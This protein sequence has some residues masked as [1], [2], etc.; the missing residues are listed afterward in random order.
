MAASHVL[1]QRAWRKMPVRLRRSSGVQRLRSIVQPTTPT[2]V[3]PSPPQR[4]VRT[5]EELDEMLGEMDKAGAISDDAIRAGFGTFRMELDTPM[6]P[7]P[8]SA[9]FRSAVLKEYELVRGEPYTLAN[10]SSHL[11]VDAAVDDPFPYSTRS[12]STVGGQLI[13]I[14]HIIKTMNLPAGS[15]ILEF[16]AGWGNTT[17]ALAQ[18]GYD[19]TVVDMEPNFLEVIRR[20]TERVGRT[21]TLLKGDFGLAE[22][23]GDDEYDAVLFFAS[24]HHCSDHVSLLRQLERVLAPGGIMMFVGENIDDTFRRPWGLRMDGE[25]LWAIRR[26]GWLE[27]GFQETYFRSTLAGFGWTCEKHPCPTSPW[28]EAFLARRAAATAPTP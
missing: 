3:T 26:H 11:D 18:A 6:P 16:G 24:F 27:L 4:V 2:P 10:E 15:R 5:I 14:G 22:T 28:G 9:D 17:L 23:L 12:P 13:A 1:L 25:S 19:V 20:R 21:V 8:H 7:D